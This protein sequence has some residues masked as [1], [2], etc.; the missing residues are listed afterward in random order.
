MDAYKAFFAK[1]TGT[2]QFGETLPEAILG[3]PGDGATVTFLSIGKFTSSEESKNCVKYTK[4]KFM[5]SLLSVLKVT[6]DNTPGKYKYVPMQN[7]TISSDIDWSK[8]IHDI[9]LQ[10]YRK[11]GLDEKEIEFIE[12]HVKE[13]A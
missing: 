1:A 10:L 11:Y 3:N 7:F 2:G 9:D 4:T 8:S 6:Q 5:R 12:T 13:M